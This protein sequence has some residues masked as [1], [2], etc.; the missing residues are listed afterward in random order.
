MKFR[1]TLFGSTIIITSFSIVGILISFLSQL[2]VAYFYGVTFFRDAY[3]IAVAIPVFISAVITGS[4]GYVFLPKINE[5]QIQKPELVRKF[6]NSTLSFFILFLTFLTIILLFFSTNIIILLIP[7]YSIEEKIFV[8]KILFIV[9]P[10]LIFNVIFNILSSLYQIEN[11]FFLPSITPILSSIVNI[12]FFL[13]L[14]KNLGI[15]A[16]AIGYLASSIFSCFVLSP[17]LKKYKFSFTFLIS[18]AHFINLLKIAI[19]LFITGLLFRS[20]TLF[21]R[22]LASKLEKG[23]IS[24]L[25]YSSQIL[26]ILATITSNGIGTSIFP[27]ISRLWTEKKM[28]SLGSF[29]NKSIRIILLVTIPIAIYFSIY[30]PQIIYFIFQRGAFTNEATLS[31]SKALAISMGAFIFQGIGTIISKLFYITGKTTIFSFIG[32]IEIISYFI[33]SY[34]LLENYSFL[35][36]SISLSVSTFISLSLSLFYVHK[37]IIKFSIT[38]IFIDISKILITS[39]ISISIIYILNNIILHNSNIFVLILITFFSS[40]IFII[41][42]YY[43]QIEEVRF[44]RSKIN[45]NFIKF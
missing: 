23:S 43:I 26:A 5:L 40:L 30:A 36:L 27:T 41:I 9:L 22:V 12:L 38:K 32:L 15:I 34:F 4:F 24:Y 13:I 45:H 1:K 16:L 14:Y 11:N 42:S 44:I 7:N 39:F 18:N 31:V 33:L 8:N 3:F 6:I 29:I 35:S 28:D 21:E 2:L 25:G 10:T 19:P 17:I 37:K 20:T